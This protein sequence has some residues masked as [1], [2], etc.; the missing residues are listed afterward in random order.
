MRTMRVSPGKVALGAAAITAIAIVGALLGSVPGWALG[1]VGA[2]R[3]GVAREGGLTVHYRASLDDN[4]LAI[5]ATRSSITR[6]GDAL[7]LEYPRLPQDSERDVLA[8]LAGGSLEMRE[9]RE[10]DAAARIGA[11]GDVRLEMDLW[12]D[13]QGDRH[14][15]PYLAGPSR[16]ALAAA[17][18]D[19]HVAPTPGTRIGYEPVR[20][21]RRAE[22]RTYELADEVAI[23]GS[24]IADAHVAFD[25]MT[26]RPIVRLD[27]TRDGAARFCDLTGRIAGHKLATIAGGRVRS[28]PVIMG[29]SAAATR[30]SRWAAPTSLPSSA[31]PPRSPRRSRRARC[32]PAARSWRRRG[33]RRPIWPR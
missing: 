22:W 1:L 15:A 24:M 13:E 16:E 17:I 12:V 18:A 31:T 8:Y 27:F 9:V 20:D 2:P 30:R 23:D 32:H 6:D 25:P 28:V 14:T 4:A 5:L 11:R 21:E 29:A 26:N 33:P 19:A 3:A 7:I 10:T